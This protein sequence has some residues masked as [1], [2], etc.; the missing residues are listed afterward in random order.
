MATYNSRYFMNKEQ[1]KA[2]AVKHTEDM[3][4]RFTKEIEKAKKESVILQDSNVKT[5][6]P[7]EKPL[8]TVCDLDSVQGAFKYKNGKTAIL[9]FA[10]YKNPGGM[11]IEGSSAQEESLCHA[12]F[13]YNV[14]KRGDIYY[15]WNKQ[16]KNKALYMNRAVYSPDILF[17]NEK[18]TENFDVITCAAPNK[19]AFMR[20]NKGD[21]KENT[22]ALKERICF[23]HNIAQQKGVETLILGAYGCGVFGQDA[24]EVANIFKEELQKSFVKNIIFAVPAGIDKKNFEAFRMTFEQNK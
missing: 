20:Y 6:E 21:E 18:E 8:F 4:N 13:L 5:F 23:I 1:R 12:S 15:D 17:F 24:L 7:K 10:S 19:T 16:H 3:E 2:K 22:F 9:N 11:F 14:L